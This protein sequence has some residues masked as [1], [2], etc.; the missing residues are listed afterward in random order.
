M[1]DCHYEPEVRP[2]WFGRYIHS[3][4]TPAYLVLD[5][6]IREVLNWNVSLSREQ[7]RE[8]GALLRQKGTYSEDQM[9]MDW[10]LEHGGKLWYRWVLYAKIVDE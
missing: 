5:E 2:Y 3:E 6:N 10:L 8:L 1:T 9:L 4:Y 7:K